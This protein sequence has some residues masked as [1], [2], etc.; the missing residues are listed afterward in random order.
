MKFNIFLWVLQV[1]LAFWFITGGI[2]MTMNYQFLIH[3]GLLKISPNFVWV[4]LGSLQILFA[5]GLVLPGLIKRFV[6]LIPISALS[7]SVI[8]LLGIVIYVSYTGVG[9]LWGLIPAV[10]TAYV[11]YGRYRLQPSR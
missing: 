10:M 8:S 7:L 4:L 6:K 11:A 2:Y 1:I 3:S 9:M 5:I